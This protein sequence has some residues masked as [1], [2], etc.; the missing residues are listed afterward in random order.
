[1]TREFYRVEQDDNGRKSVVWEAWMYIGEGEFRLETSSCR[2]YLDE[3]SEWGLEEDL[4]LELER[5]TQY[6]SVL[7]EDEFDEM[8]DDYFDGEPMEELHFDEI[9]EKTPVG[10]YYFD[11]TN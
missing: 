8:W 6:I 5:N 1:M 9:N 3:V 4:V 7:N 10:N 11:S 2:V